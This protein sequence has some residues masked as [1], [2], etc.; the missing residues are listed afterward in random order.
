MIRV[1]CNLIQCTVYIYT[2]TALVV[3]IFFRRHFRVKG[4]LIINLPCS[5]PAGGIVT[6]SYLFC[7]RVSRGGQDVINLLNGNDIACRSPRCYFFLPFFLRCP[8]YRVLVQKRKNRG[9]PC[10]DPTTTTHI[11]SRWRWKERRKQKVDLMAV[12]VLRVHL[13]FTTT[14]S[15]VYISYREF[16][17][18]FS[19]T[20]HDRLFIVCV[21][22]HRKVF[23]E[24]KGNKI[25]KKCRH[26]SAPRWGIP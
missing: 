8:K 10:R 16:S 26:H 13:L 22:V 11:P 7:G 17:S 6:F 3:V 15:V 2:Y 18:R 12:V 23:I 25:L 4:G 20:P 24:Q 1:W 9:Y 19:S 21:C 5:L 14:R